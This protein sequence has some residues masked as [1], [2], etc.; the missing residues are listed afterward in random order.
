MATE[1]TYA[2]IPASR[3]AIPPGYARQQMPGMR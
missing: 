1:V 2:P 3:F